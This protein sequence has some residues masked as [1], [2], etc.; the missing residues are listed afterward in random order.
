LGE[1]VGG[2][3]RAGFGAESAAL[4][5]DENAT[6]IRQLNATTKADGD[7]RFMGTGLADFIA[8]ENPIRTRRAIASGMNRRHC[9]LKRNRPPQFLRKK[10]GEK[11]TLLT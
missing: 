2:K 7:F 9:G 6:A 3:V 11:R 10:S 4:A 8:L 1:R 5:T